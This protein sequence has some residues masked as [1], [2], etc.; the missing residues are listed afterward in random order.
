MKKILKRKKL[1]IISAI[2]V[3]VVVI[4]VVFARRSLNS[5]V[6]ESYN[7]ELETAQVRD[8]S[9]Y[10]SLK[11]TV[12]G[13]SSMNYSSS[14]S[15]QVLTV[16]VA[17]GDEVEVGDVIVTLNQEAIQSEI[18]ALEQSISNAEALAANESAQNQRALAQ[19]K[20][21]QETQLTAANQAISSAQTAYNEAKAAY[22]EVNNQIISLT[23]QINTSA[24]ETEKESLSEQISDLSMQLSDLKSSVSSAESALTEAKTNYNT[25]KTS[26]DEAIYAAQN[27]IDME[28]YSTTDDTATRTQLDALYAELN[29]CEIVSQTSGVVTAVN[30][31]VG[32]INTPNA[33]IVT[34]ENVD[35][36]IMTVSVDEEDILSLQEGMRA[37]VTS[38]A[39][40]DEEIDGE[41]IR[42]VN[43]IS[44]SVDE[45]GGSSSGFSVEI[46]LDDCDLLSGMSAKAKIILS[47]KSKALCVP[48]DLVQYDEEGQAYI[49][50]AE[51][52]DADLEYIAVRKDI[53]IG[54]ELDY[55]AEVTG[56]DL[57]EGDYIIM[58]YSIMEGDI[59]EGSI[60]TDDDI[61]ESESVTITVG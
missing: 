21:D 37:V 55:Y 5:M 19:A 29:D 56:G 17:V 22:D 10:I 2:I 58:D 36:L 32:D 7:V 49:L 50:V 1:L 52:N 48:Y 18:N 35:T 38:D 9:D 42:V 59:F 23:N 40:P 20:A 15:S 45:Y 44:Q 3:V 31:T 47:D 39:L 11:G 61:D 24:D 57:Q 16:N 43:V 33:T 41:I 51:K 25:V 30:V 27:T 26:T 34:V 46:R 13:E 54:E 60:Y 14:A 6:E 8:L 4:L 12:S 53:E 28:Q